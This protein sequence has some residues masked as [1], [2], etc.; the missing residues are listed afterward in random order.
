MKI[1]PELLQAAT[2]C[3][4]A[5]L[6]IVAA[7]IDAATTTFNIV[8]PLDQA[9]FVAETAFESGGY[10][11]VE[12]SL[13]YAAAA[14]ASE[15]EEH[16][17]LPP[18]SPQLRRKN[19]TVVTRVDAYAFGRTATHPADQVGIANVLYGDRMGNTG[20]ASGDGYK[21]RGRGYIQLTGRENYA[22]FNHAY[23]TAPVLSIPDALCV[24]EYAALSAAWYWSKHFCGLA[25]NADDVATVASKINGGDPARPAATIKG[26][27]G[28][29]VATA[30]AK[31]AFGVRP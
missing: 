11:H 15:F 1:T 2:G 18:A 16:F 27:S 23:P 31:A 30:R 5:N 17:F 7:A 4:P 12:E 8:T 22:A 3:S 6:S 20:R 26:Y 10:Q 25:A 13:N 21:Y 28:R 19:G 14:L 29:V 9:H 24:P